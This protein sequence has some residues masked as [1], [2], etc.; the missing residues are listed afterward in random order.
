[1][2]SLKQ[3][4]GRKNM[5]PRCLVKMDLVRLPLSGYDAGPVVPLSWLTHALLDLVQ[6]VD[7]PGCDEPRLNC[8]PAEVRLMSCFHACCPP[9][10]R[11]LPAGK[12]CGGSDNNQ[13][14]TAHGKATGGTTR[15]RLLLVEA[16]PG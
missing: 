5:F 4:L 12:R 15:T 9:S 11:L 16:S 1:M 13:K 2:L 6:L 7:D 10:D 3:R 14:T 8:C